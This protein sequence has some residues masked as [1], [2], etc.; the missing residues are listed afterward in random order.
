MLKRNRF[1]DVLKGIALILIILTH[2]SFTDDKRL[3]YAFPY[4][5]DM[6]VPIFMIITGFVTAKSYE[7]KGID[8][9]DEA[10]K[11]EY[12]VRSM[13]R[14]LIPFIMIFIVEIFVMLRSNGF[15]GMP[16]IGMLAQGFLLGGNGPGA[17][18]VPIMIQLVFVFPLIHR[19][20]RLYRFN[21]VVITWLITALCEMCRMAF[22]MTQAT[23]CNLI[24]RYLPIVAYGIWLASEEYRPRPTLA[25]TG[26]IIGIGFIYAVSY[27]GYIPRIF[28]EWSG[29]SAM[30]CLYIMPIIGFFIKKC[31]N[32]HFAPLELL[33]RAS[34]N[35]FLVQ[36]VWYYLWRQVFQTDGIGEHVIARRL[37]ATYVVCIA[38]GLVFWL[39]ESRITRKLTD[40]IIPWIRKKAGA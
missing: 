36:K 2:Y 38:A 35:I 23:Y 26:M 1:L 8:S 16:G 14:F 28:N 7:R 11:P 13:L 21:G 6:G 34:F 29:T 22:Q 19:L 17:Y 27:R 9:L 39:I 33:G 10:Y 25:V 12:T 4:W 40:I 5:V 15:S 30:A 20:V 24:F 32:A 37:G 18:Y 31:E 3:L